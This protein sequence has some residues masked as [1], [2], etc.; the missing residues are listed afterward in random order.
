M[1]AQAVRA[2]RNFV[3]R[4]DA[5]ESQ[6]DVEKLVADLSEKVGLAGGGGA[7]ERWAMGASQQPR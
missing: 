3:V 7:G 6:V 1:L 2:Q 4:A 5:T